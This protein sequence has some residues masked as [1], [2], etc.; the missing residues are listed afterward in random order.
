M[1][2]LLDRPLA[3]AVGLAI[4]G[5]APAAAAPPKVSGM[6]PTGVQ[7]GVATDVTFRG[8]DLGGNP[9]LV[10]PFGFVATARPKP[11]SDGGNWH[12]TLT[13]EP[14]AAVGVYP[15]RVWTDEGLSN[16]FLF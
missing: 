7:R 12:V 14:V 11:A 16:P 15:V 3:L 2:R 5:V 1:S 4:L 8:S 13:V 9:R 6:A 10:A